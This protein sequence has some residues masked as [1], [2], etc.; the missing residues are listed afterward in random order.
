MVVSMKDT[1]SDVLDWAS[2]PEPA[3]ARLFNPKPD[4][5]LVKACSGLRLGF[6]YLKPK[7]GA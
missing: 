3:D 6:K 1:G 7:P 4:L 2:S 5:A